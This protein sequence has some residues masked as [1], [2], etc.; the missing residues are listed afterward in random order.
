MT[1]RELI[2]T[3]CTL[4]VLA[5]PRPSVLVGGTGVARLSDTAKEAFLLQAKIVKRTPISE[6]ITHTDRLTLTDG[7]A[8]HDA[9]LQCVDV[10]KDAFH[11]R[12][13][14][15][16]HFRDSYR[17]NVAAYKIDRLIGLEMV[18]VSVVRSME[19]K[20]CAVTITWTM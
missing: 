15:E 9:H 8:T 20:R 13:G 10:F 12:E 19:R 17:Y 14:T 3:L 4:L 5:A 1:R 6:G 2:P 16:L 7:N 11:G 18:P